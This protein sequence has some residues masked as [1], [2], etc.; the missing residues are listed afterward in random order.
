MD[1]GDYRPPHWRSEPCQLDAGRL[2]P[3]TTDRQ[4]LTG[5][6]KTRRKSASLPQ[7]G[8]RIRQFLCIRRNLLDATEPSQG[9][10]LPLILANSVGF[11][12]PFARFFAIFAT[13]ERFCSGICEDQQLRDC[14]A[15][16]ITFERPNRISN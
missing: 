13:F 4:Y 7:S 5:Q 1:A 15:T 11:S 16:R 3:L 6:A 14:L 10:D 12:A 2:A 8:R 9:I